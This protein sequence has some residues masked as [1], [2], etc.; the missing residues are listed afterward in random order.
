METEAV[1]RR[2]QESHLAP[3]QSLASQNGEASRRGKKHR[4]KNSKDDLIF[5]GL[6]MLLLVGVLV[7]ILIPLWYVVVISFTPYTAN[8]LQGY[9]LFLP[10]NQWTPEAYIQLFSSGA[11]V[12]A[13][14][15]S[16]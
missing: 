6:V 13:L 11:F 16:C 5:E 7:A 8:Q 14:L 1:S 12:Q 9:T 15:N 10:F 4:R 2:E 3:S